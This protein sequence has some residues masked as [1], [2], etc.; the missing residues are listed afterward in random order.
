VASRAR[1]T[2]CDILESGPCM[3]RYQTW[4]TDRRAGYWIHCPIDDRSPGCQ[5]TYLAGLATTGSRHDSPTSSGGRSLYL[6]TEPRSLGK[7]GG[8]LATTS[9][10]RAY[11]NGVHISTVEIQAIQSS[12]GLPLRHNALPSTAQPNNR[13]NRSARSRLG[14][15]TLGPSRTRLSCPFGG[16]MLDG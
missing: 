1:Y 11:E 8:F 12:T 2:R 9:T 5:T 16:Q 13:M 15:F 14:R 10:S 4:S 3:G 6:R 7:G